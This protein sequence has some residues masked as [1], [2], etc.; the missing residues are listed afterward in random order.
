MGNA[1][2]DI[3]GYD[4]EIVTTGTFARSSNFNESTAGNTSG[5]LTYE[6]IH[7]IGGFPLFSN[8]GN[9]F[10]VHSQ[11]NSGSSV[12][13]ATPV[14]FWY[15]G[16][17]G[18]EVLSLGNQTVAVIQGTTVQ[19]KGSGAQS[20]ISWLTG[21]TLAIG[22]GTY[23][24][25][26]GSLKLQSISFGGATSDVS[27]DVAAA[28]MAMSSAYLL[29]WNF[30]TGISRVSAGVVGIGSGTA[31]STVGTLSC[32]NVDVRS[33]SNAPL[34]VTSSFSGVSAAT[35][36]NSSSSGESRVTVQNDLGSIVVL[37]LLGSAAAAGLAG[38]AFIFTQDGSS[39]VP[40]MAFATNA[41]GATGGTTPILFM[42]GG[43][44]VTPQLSALPNGVVAI[45]GT[46]NALSS[47]L[48]F[49]TGISR[50]AAGSFAFGNATASSTSGN[51]SFNRISKAGTDFAGQATVTAGQTTEA[52]TFAAN[53]AGTGQPVI[54][55]T[56][57]SDP[58]AL[59]VPV[60][61]WVTY[62]GSAGAWTGFTVNIQTTL[63]G[64]V[65]FNYIVIG[66]A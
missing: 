28:T 27:I 32:A 62:S 18:T 17:N 10:E 26:T 42:S 11:T 54:V 1:R 35:F 13:F 60:G 21:A 64:N 33:A 22:N 23:Q 51:L 65:T 15:H 61:Y 12:D 14:N 31:G 34:T 24:D 30:D 25:V 16:L 43:Y 44:Q 41:E 2:V 50:L 20:S 47:S 48:V 53:Y 46:G 63:A 56:P 3:L 39:T 55:L 49:D 40:Y 29:A 37:E 66:V 5:I 8:G 36:S 52:V 58:L 6:A 57:T 45:G 4:L 38:S 9:L 59:G 19:F 7:G